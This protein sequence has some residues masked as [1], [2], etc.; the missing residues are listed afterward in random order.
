MQVSGGQYK[1]VVMQPAAVATGN[2]TAIECTEVAGGACKQLA[3]QVQG[4]TTATITWEATIDSTNWKG[5]LVTP[6]DTGTAAL[7]ATAD[8]IFRVDV[9]GLAQ[10]RARI[11]AWTS[12]AITVTGILAAV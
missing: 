5:L 7:T 4:I 9:T 11:S 10:F 2:G 6:L 1:T 3:L 12:G 8:G